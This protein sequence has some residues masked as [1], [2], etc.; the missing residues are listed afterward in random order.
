[1]EGRSKM[2]DK[3][4]QLQWI[5]GFNVDTNIGNSIT[6][7]HL[8]YADDTLI[9]CQPVT[10]QLLYLN[11]TLLLFEALSGLHITVLKSIMYLVNDVPNLEEL[12][13]IM[14]CTIGSL[15]TTYLGLFLGARYK[16][17][18][19]WN[20]IIRKFEKAAVSFH[21]RETNSHQ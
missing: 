4:N 3:A 15:P 19:I 17:T 6:M 9:F 14:G 13:N 5:K 18:E 2:L 12:S 1:M 16:N 21:G 8:L 11:L 7:S 10:S 20:G